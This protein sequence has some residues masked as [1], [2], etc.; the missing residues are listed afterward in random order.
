[1]LRRWREVKVRLRKRSKQ[2]FHILPVDLK[3]CTI[4]MRPIT[5]IDFV[6]VHVCDFK[7]SLL[8]EDDFQA[9]FVFIKL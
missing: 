6:I 2:G 4:P 3:C 9:P 5:E 1:M 8:I 7:L